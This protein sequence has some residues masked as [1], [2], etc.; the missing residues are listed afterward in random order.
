MYS[1]EEIEGSVTG[2]IIHVISPRNVRN[3]IQLKRQKFIKKTSKILWK[4]RKIFWP[5]IDIST[6][7]PEPTGTH[8]FEIRVGSTRNPGTHGFLGSA[9]ADPWFW[10]QI[11]N[12]DLRS[13]IL[14]SNLSFKSQI[15]IPP[16]KMKIRRP[17]IMILSWSLKRC[18]V[19]C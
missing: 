10:P 7:N 12:F 5:L 13:K 15:K 9:H 1:Q 18:E 2:L 16:W 19:E 6:W 3:K 14:T 17:S 11:W 8:I 4:N